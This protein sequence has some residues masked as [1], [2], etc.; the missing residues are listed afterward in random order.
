MRFKPAMV[1][2]EPLSAIAY[3]VAPIFTV[4]DG[5]MRFSA[6]TAFTISLGVN[7]LA[8]SAAVS[9]STEIWRDFPPKGNGTAAPG[10]VTRRGRRKLKAASNSAGSVIVGLDRPSWITGMAD[11]EYLMT[12][13]GKAPGGS[14]RNC[15]CSM[16]TTWAMA[17]GI[18]A[19]GWKKILMMDRP[20]SDCDSMCSISLTVV[21]RLRSLT[22]VIRW[23]TSCADSPLY[24]QTMLMTGILISGKMS[25]D[26][27][28]RTRGVARR[29]SS[30]ITKNVYGR[31]SAT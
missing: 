22:A 20:A 28:S 6:F 21:V 17:V 30:A 25:V 18:F 10:I 15:D 26:I 13:G 23:P 14:C 29:I 31:R 11:A 16:A 24:V 19:F 8:R 3:S 9:R 7:P 12:S 4:P 5:S 1:S 2:G 27:L